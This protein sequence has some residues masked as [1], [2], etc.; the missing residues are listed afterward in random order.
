MLKTICLYRLGGRVGEARAT[1]D[2]AEA[3]MQSRLLDRLNESEG[4]LDQSERTYLIHRREAQSLLGL[5]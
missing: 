2:E 4:F 3:I 1:F 5:K